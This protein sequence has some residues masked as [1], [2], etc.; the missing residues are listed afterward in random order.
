MRRWADYR[1]FL[2]ACDAL[3]TGLGYLVGPDEMRRSPALAY[4]NALPGGMRGIGAALLLVAALLILGRFVWT[5][6]TMRRWGHAIGAGLYFLL[7]V[8]IISV[9]FLPE[10]AGASWIHL[11]V[12]MGMHLRAAS[13]T[14][15]KRMPDDDR[16]AP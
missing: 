4:F 14:P 7:A 15:V 5:H 3:L 2:L 6:S 1:E 11:L 10:D 13:E 9:L 16:G 8:G 12:L